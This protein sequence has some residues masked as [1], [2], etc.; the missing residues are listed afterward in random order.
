MAL[1]PVMLDLEGTALTDAERELLHHPNVGGVI[2]FARNCAGPDQI[3]ALTAELHALRDP[4]LLIGVDQ[5]GGRVQRCRTGFTP[6]PAM[7]RLGERFQQDPADAEAS[8]HSL[9]WL[10][11]AELL[12]VG[13]D[14]GFAPVLDLQRGVSAVIGDRAFHSAPE[15]VTRLGGAV[16]R[17]MGEAGMAGVGKHFPGHGSVAADS[18]HAQPVDPRPRHELLEIDAVPFAHLVQ[19]G[20]AGIMPGHVVYP[21]V[22]AVPAGFSRVWLDEILRGQLGFAGTIFSDDLSM[23]GAGTDPGCAR[24]AQDALAAGCDMVLVCNDRAGALETLDALG[25]IERPMTAAR[26][27]RMHGQAAPGIDRELGRT[28]AWRAAHARVERLKRADEPTPDRGT[29]DHG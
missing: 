10:L 9:G 26:L 15:A 25:R 11:A 23:V 5:E 19:Q 8:A 3:A 6:L 17:G 18:H 16:V 13:I 27:M 7:A 22:D 14:I 21:D 24:R 28:P 29:A 12:A 20:L 2:L 4:P 1:G